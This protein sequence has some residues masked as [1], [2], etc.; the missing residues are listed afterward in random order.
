VG[1]SGDLTPEA[2]AAALPGRPCRAYPA[3]LSTDAVAVEWARGGAP[4]GAVVAA[5]YQ[6]SARGRGG[7]PWTI[8]PGRDLCFSLVLRPAIT[9][10]DEGWVFVAAALAVLEV[11]GGEVAVEWPDRIVRDGRPVADVAGHAGLGAN[12]VAWVI[13]NLLL[14]DAA[15]PR[16]ALLRQLAEAV[17]RVQ[18]PE[19]AALARFSE[20]CTTLGREVVAHV[21]PVWPDGVQISGRA[22]SV[23]EDGALVIERSDGSR[24]A[25][26]PQHLARLEAPD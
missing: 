10:D 3:L 20:R 7:L 17:E 24:V 4:A 25:V 22:V 1:L 23:L 5:D 11:L 13:V 2:L 18:Q 14:L 21:I 16:A 15:A 19:A 6:A 12:G 8:R 26:R 9:A